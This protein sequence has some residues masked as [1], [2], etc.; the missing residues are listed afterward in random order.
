MKISDN[1]RS[2]GKICFLHL[3]TLFFTAQTCT[4]NS[5]LNSFVFFYSNSTGCIYRTKFFI[6]HRRSNHHCRRI[7]FIS[8][9]L[10]QTDGDTHK[11]NS[12]VGTKFCCK[13]HTTPL[14]T[15]SVNTTLAQTNPKS[16]KGS[17]TGVITITSN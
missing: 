5:D 3:P 9:T 2:G 11:S 16:H 14:I 7:R 12:E 4:K 1:F 17:Q 10:T 13:D 6:K 8:P 15:S